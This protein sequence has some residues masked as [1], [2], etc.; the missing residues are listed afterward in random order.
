MV[1]GIADDLDAAAT[2]R[3][4]V[5][6]G[7]G[8]CGVVGAFGVNVRANLAN[9]GA[10]IEFWKNHDGVHVRERREN[11]CALLLGHERASFAFEGANGFVGVDGDDQLSAECFRPA[12]IAHV[13]D[14][15]KI[16]IP[17]GER[18]AFAGAAPLLDLRAQFVAVQ[19][20][21]F[22]VWLWSLNVFGVHGFFNILGAGF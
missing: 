2:F 6:L 16:E 11:F 20:L 18:D 4:G 21:V 10:H 12:Q 7:D 13:A 22:A 5:A 17:V 1:F 19:N 15:Q 9:D 14:V 8:F 3:Y